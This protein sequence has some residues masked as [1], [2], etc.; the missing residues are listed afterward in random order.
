LLA[1]RNANC[2]IP[3]MQVQEII[4][5]PAVTRIPNMPDFLEGIINLR[6][7][8][9]PIV[10]MRKRFR[11]E[12]REKTEETRIIVVAIEGQSVGLVSDYVS[13]VIR[14]P[15]GSID[16]VPSVVSQVES[17]YL[18]GVGKVDKRL[19]IL[20]NIE[21]VLSALERTSLRKFDTEMSSA[22]A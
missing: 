3:I 10:D 12:Q 16:P 1:G 5:P 15:K 14:L 22:G 20:L 19:I 17:E 2:D 9:I 7:K 8:I 11:L 4:K 13:D 18:S 6:G 21:K